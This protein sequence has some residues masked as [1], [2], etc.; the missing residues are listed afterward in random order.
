MTYVTASQ[1]AS[2]IN[3][4]DRIYVHG[5]ACTPNFILEAITQ[6]ARELKDVEFYHIHTLGDALYADIKYKDSFKVNSLFTGANVRHTIKQGNGSYI[7]AFLQDMPG[8]FDNQILHLDVALIQVSS[9]DQHGYVSLGTSV[10]STLA[11]IR[12]AKTVIA[13]VNKFMPRTFGDSCLHISQITCLVEHN[14]PLLE[15]FVVSAASEQEELIGDHIAKMIENGSTLQMGIGTIPEVVLQKL[16]NHKNLG[17][18]TEMFSDGVIDLIEAGALNG[19]QK[20]IDKGKA[21]ATFAV[22]SQRLY[23]YMDNN[24]LFLLKEC[25]YTNDPSIIKQNPKVIAINSAV[26]IDLTGQICADS[27]GPRIYSGVGGQVDF[28]RGATLSKGGKAIIAMTSTTKKGESKI[29]P[30]L[31]QGAGVVTSRAHVQYV[32]TEYG[33]ADLRGKNLIQRAHLLSSIAHPDHRQS[34]LQTYLQSIK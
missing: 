17:L 27:I 1:A 20:S 30:F 5:I 22:G 19:S 29:V 8:L 12:N 10:E 14:T 15:E 23:D 11:A 34:I 4:G 2:L 25:S 7:P 26:E 28:V 6:R 31:K 21:V 3:S 24:P 32:V 13:Q 18:H 33:V 16:R 9:M